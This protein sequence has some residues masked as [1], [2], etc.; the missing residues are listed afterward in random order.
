M[1]QDE[2]YGKFRF[3]ADNEWVYGSRSQTSIKTFFAGNHEQS[4]RRQPLIVNADQPVFLAGENTAPN[5][6]EHYLNSL[7][8][9]INT[10]VV[11]H[12]SVQDIPIEALKVSAEGEMDARGFFGVSEDVNRGYNKIRVNISAKMPVKKEKFKELISYSPVYEMVAKAIPVELN[13]NID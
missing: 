4:E 5:A 12:S 13:I 10:T 6:V 7:V 2:T 1:S 8:C 11:A 9:C 3:K